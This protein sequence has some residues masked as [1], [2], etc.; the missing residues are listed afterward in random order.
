M[1]I[2]LGWR[3]FILIFPLLISFLYLLYFISKKAAVVVP[4][5]VHQDNPRTGFPYSKAGK[6]VRRKKTLKRHPSWK[7]PQKAAGG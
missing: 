7:E 3:C 4:K 5:A 2:Y 1:K 6:E